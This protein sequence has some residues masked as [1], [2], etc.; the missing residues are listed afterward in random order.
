MRHL[1]AL[2]NALPVS[3]ANQDRAGKASGNGGASSHFQAA[4]GRSEPL[5]RVVMLLSAP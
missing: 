4:G 3:V 5:R 1:Y 2:D